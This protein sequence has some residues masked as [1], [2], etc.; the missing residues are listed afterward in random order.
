MREFYR[1]QRRRLVTRQV[2]GMAVVEKCLL[3]KKA[4]LLAPLSFK[5]VCS[6]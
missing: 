2:R 5:L 6:F 4:R 1:Q 3:R